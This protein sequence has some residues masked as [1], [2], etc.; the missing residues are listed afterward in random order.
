[1]NRSYIYRPSLFFGVVILSSWICSL[2]VIYFSKQADME[3]IQLFLL[4]SLCIPCITALAMIYK[5]NNSNLKKDFWDRLSFCRIKV[6]FF[7]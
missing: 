6:N 7:L 2:P 1:M 3:W 4:L 5:S